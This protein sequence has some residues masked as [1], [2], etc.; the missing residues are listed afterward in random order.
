[1]GHAAEPFDA[2]RG[3]V[4]EG[5]PAVGFRT[6]AD[7]VDAYLGCRENAEPLVDLAAGGRREAEDGH[8]PAHAEH[9]AEH[10]EHRPGGA[11]QHADQGLADQVPWVQPGRLDPM[12]AAESHRRASPTGAAVTSR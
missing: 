10:R 8:E 1:V 2:V 9:G 3:V 5:D 7:V 6:R 11:L 4:R 12:G